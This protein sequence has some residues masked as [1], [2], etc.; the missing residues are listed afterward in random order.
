MVGYFISAAGLA[1]L[2]GGPIL[3]AA[4]GSGDDL[5]ASPVTGSDA[6]IATSAVP[7]ATPDWTGSAPPVPDNP[8]PLDPAFI[9]AAIE[10]LGGNSYFATS[11][12]DRFEVLTSFPSMDEVT[13]DVAGVVLVIE[14]AEPIS[15]P[16]GRPT[17]EGREEGASG[18]LV[19]IVSSEWTEPASHFEITVRTDLTVRFI[20]PFPEELATRY[21]SG[22]VA[23][24]G[25]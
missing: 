6:S 18:P 17:W 25:L 10:A 12:G 7:Q 11:I 14:V 15:L 5:E 24:A 19:E 2:V 13:N 23:E 16:P 22:T 1:V 4:A 21:T 9:D 8:I 3:R 20:A